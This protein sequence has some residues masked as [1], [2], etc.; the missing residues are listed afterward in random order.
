MSGGSSAGRAFRLLR[1]PGCRWTLSRG[2]AGYPSEPLTHPIDVETPLRDAGSADRLAQSLSTGGKET[3][4]TRLENGLRVAS[5]EAFGQYST[6]GVFVDA[7][8]RYE[9]EHTSG[10]SHFLQK[11]AFQS[12]EKFPS[13]EALLHELDQYGGVFDCQRSRDV[14]I[15]SLSAFSFAIPQAMEVLSDCIWRPR[16]TREELEMERQSINFELETVKNGPSSEVWTTDLIHQAAYRDNTLGLPSLCPEENIPIIQ[17]DELMGYLAGHYLPTR[18]VLAGVNVDHDRFVGLAREWFGRTEPVWGDRGTE[19]TVDHS[20]SQYTGGAVKVER[21]GPPVVGPN[22][23][24]DLTHVV[25]AC[26]SSSYL[27]P[28]FYTF[29]V[30]NSL[31]GGGGSFSA[32]GPGKGMYTR[33]Y[34]DVLTRH[35]WIYSALAQNHAY[36]DSGIFCLF[37]SAAPA[38]A[39]ELTEVLCMEFIGMTREPEEV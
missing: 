20:L 29:A 38:M 33:L 25:L 13:R 12:T 32:G 11:L 2:L 17:R 21:E 16:I 3:R 1:S 4:I 9:V 28:D 22:P 37:G 31:M 6:I 30:L 23:L 24:P 8:S 39:R 36:S 19:R 10:V 18:M 7:G 34:Q 26:E 5:Q 14:V 27:D 15:Y 35:H